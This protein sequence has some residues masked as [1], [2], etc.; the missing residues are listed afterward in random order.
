MG[1][2]V[3]LG[4]FPK[5]ENNSSDLFLVL[6]PQS[7]KTC[8]NGGGR[9]EGAVGERKIWM[10]VLSLRLL[11]IKSPSQMTGMGTKEHTNNKQNNPRQS[12][13]PGGLRGTLCRLFRV[14][15]GGQGSL[16]AIKP[17]SKQ[18]WRR[19]AK[20]ELDGNRE[21]GLPS[22]EDPPLDC[23]DL[24]FV[25]AQLVHPNIPP[26]HPTPQ[27]TP[28]GALQLQVVLDFI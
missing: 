6:Q 12:K 7:N 10:E 8:Q 15:L 20:K 5:T 16:L 3:H 25:I 26:A 21:G 27:K 28:H 9:E 19:A 11:M 23:S 14:P 4:K 22:K 13:H 17:I 18:G 1:Q 2:I 24:P